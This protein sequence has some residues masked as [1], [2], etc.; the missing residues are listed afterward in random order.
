MLGF[1]KRWIRTSRAGSAVLRMGRRHP[2]LRKWG[3]SV[4]GNFSLLSCKISPGGVAFD[5]N[6]KTLVLVVHNASVSG[7]PIL[8]LNLTSQFAHSYNVIVMMLTGGALDQ[9]LE[10]AGVAAVKP[11]FGSM[12]EASPTLMATAVLGRIKWGFGLDIVLANS[13]ECAVAVAAADSAR[14]SCISL[15]H[16]FAEY[17]DP[18]HLALTV[19]HA[20]RIVFSSQV[21]ANSYMSFHD[22]DNDRR[23]VIPQGRSA[24]PSNE[25]AIC[26]QSYLQRPIQSDEVL[27]LGCGRVEMRKGTDLFIE[28]AIGALRRS[29]KLRFIW[30][31]EG[32]GDDCYPNYRFWLKDYIS[33]SGLT[34]HIELI[35]AVHGRN[36]QDLFR[37]A[38]IMFLS[39][40]LDP[41]PNVAIDAMHEG[42]PVVC[43]ERA[44]GLAEYLAT[45][46]ALK[47][48]II[49][50]LD[51]GAA[52]EV[53][54]NL[55]EN[56]ELREAM[57][58]SSILVAKS[59][60][61]MTHYVEKLLSNLADI[62][63]KK[64]R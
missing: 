50:Y 40:R 20:D 19:H 17:S 53:I 63:K 37:D 56:F 16:E 58:Q 62:E 43:F 24:V 34:G 15:I 18:H 22:I 46:P 42:V 26:Y 6:K 21:I 48:L 7:A 41:L 29:S 36:L 39:S 2:S 57:S 5:A 4:F 10:A 55:A 1:V 49:D 61:D 27:C 45:D 35:P 52:S 8:G 25:L 54:A 12:R 11:R 38:K 13:V 64:V 3:L 30:V 14:I 33:R 44:T 32:D 60:F 59:L 47:P 28:A 23:T 31:G 51:T 9:N